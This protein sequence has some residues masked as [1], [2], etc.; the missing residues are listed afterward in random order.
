MRLEPRLAEA[1]QEA[2]Q[3]IAGRGLFAQ[4]RELTPEVRVDE[5]AQVF[6]LERFHEH[7]VMLEAEQFVLIPSISVWPHVRVNCDTPWPYALIYPAPWV[8]R[9]ARPQLPPGEL[10]RLL[11][12]LGD[13]TRLRALRCI[14]RRPRSTQELAQ[15]VQV[16]EA[17]MSKHL[18]RLSDAGLLTSHREGYYVLYEL[19]PNRL[20]ALSPSLASFLLDVAADAQ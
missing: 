12:A 8:A 13:D 17:A 16:S 14:A 19:L 10:L 20:A 1:V 9:Q 3:S 2:G 4:L 18:R 5:E 7:E 11:Q 15:L 6:W